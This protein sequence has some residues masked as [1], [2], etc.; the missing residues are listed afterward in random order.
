MPRDKPWSDES[1]LI[2]L[3][4]EKGYSTHEIAEKLGCNQTTVCYWMDKHEVKSRDR[5]EAVVSSIRSRPARFV[6]NED[7]YECWFT[8]SR[9]KGWQVQVHR[10]LAASELGL[11]EIDS[12]D[13]HHKNGIPWDN[14]PEN[15][16]VL[17]R[18]EH[19]KRHRE[20]KQPERLAIAALYESTDLSQAKVAD[21]FGTCGSMVHR[22]HK[23]VFGR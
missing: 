4:H 14:R 2:N 18:R 10:L 9:D 5:V 1:T 7:G 15:I 22:I 6:T 17:N 12:K 20:I 13:V 21:R 19:R 11:D 16:E 23:E 3:Y 8:R